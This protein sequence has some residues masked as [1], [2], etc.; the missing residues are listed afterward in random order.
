MPDRATLDDWLAKVDSLLHDLRHY[1]PQHMRED[2]D[3]S[4]PVRPDDGDS[5]L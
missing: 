4:I 2:V 3:E 5:G 1:L